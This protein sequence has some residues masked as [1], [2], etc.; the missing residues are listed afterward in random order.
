MSNLLLLLPGGRRQW[1]GL[2]S[3]RRPGISLPVSAVVR[4]VGEGASERHER[5]PE[6]ASGFISPNG[7][8]LGCTGDGCHWASWAVFWGGVVR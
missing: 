8:G 1:R 2:L 3:R 4:G 5:V 6:G 7:H